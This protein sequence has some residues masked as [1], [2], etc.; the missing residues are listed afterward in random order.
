MIV[1]GVLMIVCGVLMIVCG[2]LLSFSVLCN[3]PFCKLS[4]RTVASCNL[5]TYGVLQQLCS[6]A[7]LHNCQKQPSAHL[8]PSKKSL[9]LFIV[10]GQVAVLSP[11]IC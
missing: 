11:L 5:W 3:I 6:C 2:V 9:T 10:M 1:C 7:Q 4:F 8:S